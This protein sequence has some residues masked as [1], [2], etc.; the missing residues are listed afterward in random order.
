M[1][2]TPTAV[3]KSVAG[4]I[5]RFDRGRVL[6]K[7]TNELR[8]LCR[9]V[10]LLRKPGQLVITIKVRPGEHGAALT[11]SCSSK[12]TL[13]EEDAVTQAYWIDAEGHPTRNSP[14]QP[15]LADDMEPDVL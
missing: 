2:T 5:E 11:A 8:D 7:A 4:F 14:E 13:P 9:A 15:A 1:T 6:A 10:D 12:V 3:K